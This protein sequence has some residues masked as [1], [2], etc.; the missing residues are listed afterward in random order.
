MSVGEQATKA[1]M[2]QAFTSL[3][4]QMRNLMQQ[5]QN[6]WVN[7]N[8]GAAGSASDVLVRM[9]Y[10]NTNSDAPGSQSD[11]AYADYVLNTMNTMAQ[12]FFGNAVQ[13]DTFDFANALAPV[14]A[15]QA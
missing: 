8:N 3:A 9:G 7:V 2:D 10:D 12:I 4:V 15:G 14:M 1:G 6:E 13:P 5:V 11:A